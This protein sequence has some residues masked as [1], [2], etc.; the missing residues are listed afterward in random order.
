MGKIYVE[1]NMPKKKRKLHRAVGILLAVAVT[2]QAMPFDG[3]TVFAAEEVQSAEA[4]AACIHE[5]EESCY[6][7]ATTSEEG[8]TFT[9]EENKQPTECRHSCSEESGCITKELDCRHDHNASCGYTQETSSEEETTESPSTF[10]GEIYNDETTEDTAVNN[11]AAAPMDSRAGQQASNEASVTIDGEVSYYATAEE[12]F[13]AANG[14]TAEVALLKDAEVERICLNAGDITYR[15]GSYTLRIT[16]GSSSNKDSICLEGNASMTIEDGTIAGTKY[17]VVVN[18]RQCSLAINGGS[19]TGEYGVTIYFG[20]MEITGGS[21][22]GTDK[23]LYIQGG[24][25]QISGTFRETERDFL[26]RIMAGLRSW[27]SRAVHSM[28]NWT[29]N[30]AYPS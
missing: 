10:V 13:A 5:H 23:A 16:A 19:I 2:C 28:G 29:L 9:E 3:I 20:S 6:P 25:T 8:E 27:N 21:V 22:T 15:G 1:K 7:E 4:A 11:D 26:C 24:A 30:L 18:S 17:A 14:Q 12:A